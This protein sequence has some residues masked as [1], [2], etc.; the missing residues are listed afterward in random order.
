MNK[1]SKAIL[2][3]IDRSKHR[4]TRKND[5]REMFSSYK[6]MLIMYSKEK[7]IVTKYYA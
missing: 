2:M 1:Q 5:V 3:T 6:Q 4:M 7:I